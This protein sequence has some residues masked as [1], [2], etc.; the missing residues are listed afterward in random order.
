[1]V[2]LIKHFHHH[3]QRSCENPGSSPHYPPTVQAKEFEGY[4]ECIPFSYS[5]QESRFTHIE[6]ITLEIEDKLANFL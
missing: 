4:S 2:H 6:E 1:M 3:V 5:I